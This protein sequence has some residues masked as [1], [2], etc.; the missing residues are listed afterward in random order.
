VYNTL[1]EFHIDKYQE[2]TELIAEAARVLM[3]NE[4]STLIAVRHI[5]HGNK[6]KELLPCA[7]EIYAETYNRVQLFDEFRNGKI[8]VV[9]S[10]L[11]KEGID[12]P[13]CSAVII[14]HDTQDAQQLVGRI[15][16]LYPG[17]ERAIVVHMVDEHPIFKKHIKYNE[18]VFYKPQK[19]ATEYIT[20]D[21][22][23]KVLQ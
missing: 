14:A 8:P 3:H 5:D 20:E 23:A 10:T 15:V 6:I 17:K 1:R 4:H 11:C 22:L 13:R 16:R 18:K 2:R 12:I 9:I 21:D 19:I 7:V